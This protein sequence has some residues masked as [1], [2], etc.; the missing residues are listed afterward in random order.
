M[1]SIKKWARMWNAGMPK[2][3]FCLKIS[4]GMS[5]H[6]FVPAREVRWWWWLKWALRHMVRLNSTRLNWWSRCWPWFLITLKHNLN[7][8]QKSVGNY[9]AFFY[10]E[11]VNVPLGPD[12][13]RV[14]TVHPAICGRDFE[15]VK[16]G[17]PIL[18][19]FFG[20]DIYWEREQDI[21]PHF[22][23][24]SACSTKLTLRW[25]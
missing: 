3:I 25:H 17:E 15:V 19:T 22:I 21:Y 10:V 1:L 8:V 23:N 5:S 9:D 13:V 4:L 7:Q 16:Q 18:A 14:A 2:L 20:Y 24:G 6:T 11:E 12:G